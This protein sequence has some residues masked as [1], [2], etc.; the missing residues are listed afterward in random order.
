MIRFLTSIVLLFCLIPVAQSQ[1]HTEE[2][3]RV[4][5]IGLDTSHAS[6]FSRVLNDPQSA[7]EFSGCRVV[8]AVS[9]HSPN[10][11]ESVRYW[12]KVTKEIQA[13]G[14]EIVP[15]IDEMLKRVDVV[16]LESIDGN[17]HPAQALPVLRARKPMFVD[18]PVAGSL[19][20]AVLLY[21]IARH[22]RT[23]VFSSSSLRYTDGA[24]AIA[25]GSVGEIKGCDAF[26]PCPVE[27]T[28]PD[29]FWYGIHGVETLFTVMGPGCESVTRV[30]S[31]NT[32]VAVGLWQDGRIGTFRGRRKDNNGYAGGYGGTAFGTKGITEIGGF[33]GYEPLVAEIVRFFKT[34]K[35]PVSAQE[36]LEIYAFME[37]A[38]ES[39]RRNGAPV[40]LSDVLATARRT[41]QTRM[42]ALLAP[43]T[44]TV[45]VQQK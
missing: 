10:V 30:H 20:D 2:V 17:P 26:S 28:H 16:L 32:D 23:P 29:F 9:S 12:P 13:L 36:T 44:E 40:R 37:A 19:T 43:P 14:I 33:S 8:A 6:A 7:P 18:K 21:D 27:P 22:F 45:P 42:N 1:E 15:S 25:A 11:A 4:G 41:A 35:A 3:L 34:G 39:R 5:V 38:D 31:A 24:K